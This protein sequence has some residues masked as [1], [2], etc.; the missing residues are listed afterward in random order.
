VCVDVER[1]QRGAVALEHQCGAAIAR[2]FDDD[3]GARGEEQPADDVQR[4]L[5]ARCD[6][7][8]LGGGAQSARILEMLRNCLPKLRHPERIAIFRERA[9]HV[10]HAADLRQLSE[11]AGRDQAGIR[12]PRPEIDLLADGRS[13]REDRALSTE[14]DRR[15]LCAVRTRLT[16]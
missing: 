1:K 16:G 7:D 2:I 9:P 3:F 4:F 10:R 11:Q 5:D 13:V 6:D 8:L 15:P 14:N 12:T